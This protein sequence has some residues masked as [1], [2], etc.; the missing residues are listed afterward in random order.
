MKA[1]I[2]SLVMAIAM[3]IG[4][5]LPSALAVSKDYIVWTIFIYGYPG[6]ILAAIIVLF[7]WYL[8]TKTVKK[9]DT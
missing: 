1:S 6:I 5:A 7:I 8:L 3:I 2:G 9:P 4:A